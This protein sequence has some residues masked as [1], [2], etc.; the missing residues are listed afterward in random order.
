MIIL[1][2]RVYQT[3]AETWDFRL[4]SEDP[5]IKHDLNEWY[6]NGTAF[7]RTRNGHLWVVG[8]T[9]HHTTDEALHHI[10]D[11]ARS[12]RDL[13]RMGLSDI[14]VDGIDFVNL[15]ENMAFCPFCRELVKPG[16][17]CRS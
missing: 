5:V 9:F 15:C 13:D 4:V 11:I 14:T 17:Q 3:H 8:H 2:L 7:M 1:A 16:K 12:L 6:M 10:E